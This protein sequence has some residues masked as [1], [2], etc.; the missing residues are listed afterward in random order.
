M[1]NIGLPCDPKIEPWTID[2]LRYLTKTKDHKLSFNM[3]RQR[4]GRIVKEELHDISPDIRTHHLRHFRLTHLVQD[5]GFAPIDLIT[6]AGW[7]FKSGLHSIGQSSGQLDSYIHLSWKS[8]I[9]KLMVPI[10]EVL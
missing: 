9:N 8:Y 4:V 2:V 10:N 5:Y 7:S 1:Q 6:F 3:T